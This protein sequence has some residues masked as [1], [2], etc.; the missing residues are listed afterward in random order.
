MSM[1]ETILM[2]IYIF[3]FHLRGKSEGEFNGA[4]AL[5]RKFNIE[6]IFI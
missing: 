3:L 1:Y 5:Q 4:V 6:Q 2:K